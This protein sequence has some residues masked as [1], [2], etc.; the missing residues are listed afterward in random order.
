MIEINRWARKEDLV[1]CIGHD[2][3]PKD[4]R[5]G[6]TAHTV[7]VGKEWKASTI[8][9]QGYIYGPIGYGVLSPKEYVIL[10]DVS[11]LEENPDFSEI[12]PSFDEILH[13]GQYGS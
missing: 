8:L 2:H 4:S 5:N 13:G 11:E 1:R 10:E 7:E 6:F 12:K 3:L 9:E